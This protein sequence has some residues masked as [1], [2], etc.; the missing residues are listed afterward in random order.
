MLDKTGV[1]FLLLTRSIQYQINNRKLCLHKS[2]LL[3]WSDFN[4]FCRVFGFVRIWWNGS[5]KCTSVIKLV[6]VRVRHCVIRELRNS[7]YSY[8]SC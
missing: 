7:P 5:A 6:S 4:F 3:L 2:T 8:D 1:S